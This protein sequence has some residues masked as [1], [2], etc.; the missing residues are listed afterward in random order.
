MIFLLGIYVPYRRFT[1][2][3]IFYTVHRLHSREHGVVHII[4]SVHTV[5]ADTIKVINTIKVFTHLVEFV[6]CAKVSGVSL[7]DPYTN[8]VLNVG[9]IDDTDFFEL[10]K[11]KLSELPVGHIPVFVALV[12]E[13]F[14]SHPNGV[15]R[16]LD[17]IG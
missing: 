8:G 15:L 4:V 3:F 2:G 13:V 11:S 5:S 9:F 14:E 17:H 7:F 12:T 16:V 6:V 1:Q 10:V